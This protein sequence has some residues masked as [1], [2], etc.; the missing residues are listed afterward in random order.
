MLDR[1][2][3]AYLVSL[4]GNEQYDSAQGVLELVRGIRQRPALRRL[5]DSILFVEQP[6][7]RKL[8]LESTCGRTTRA[9]R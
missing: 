4:N 5:W 2:H 8:A 9:G 6:I 7:A 1:A 3:A